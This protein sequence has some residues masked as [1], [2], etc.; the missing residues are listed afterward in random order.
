[1]PYPPLKTENYQ[2]I[3]GIN[4]KASPYMTGTNETLDLLNLDFTTPGAYTTRPGTTGWISGLTGPVLS[5]TQFSRLNGASYLIFTNNGNLYSY[6]GGSLHVQASGSTATLLSFAPFVDRLFL[7]DGVGFL[8]DTGTSV[9]AFSLPPP[10]GANMFNSEAVSNATTTGFTG[11]FVYGFAWV[12]D[13]GYIGPVAANNYNDI[14]SGIPIYDFPGIQFSIAGGSYIIFTLN[15]LANVPAGYGISYLAIFRAGPIAGNGIPFA[16]PVAAV[17]YIPAWYQLTNL[18]LSQVTFIDQAA[19]YGPA[20][21]TGPTLGSQALWFTLAPR[22]L[23]VYNNALF[24]AGFSSLPSTV[25]FSA[26]GEPELIGVTQ[27][28]QVR[29]NDSDVLTGMCNYISQQM[30]FKNRSFFS[31]NGTDSTNYTLNQISDEYGCISNRAAVVFND[32]L[33]FL[34]QK[35]LCQYNGSQVE[36]ISNRLESVFKRMN[37]VAAQDHAAMLHVKLRNEVWALFPIDGATFNNHLVVYDYVANAFSEWSGP[38]MASMALMF[39]PNNQFTPTFG[40]YTSS[41]NYFNATLF[42]DNGR[43]FTCS[44]TPRYFGGQGQEL[45]YSVEKVFR[46]LYFDITDSSNTGQTTIFDIKLLADFTGM[47]LAGRQTFAMAAGHTQIR[48]DFGVPGKAMTYQMAYLPQT[49]AL[50][51]NGFT[52][53]YRFQRN[54]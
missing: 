45:G 19:T 34:D 43:A 52:I 20:N 46:R 42:T 21:P 50:N 24:M 27:S 35:G 10:P 53:E 12:N 29:T 54:T 32:I 26:V 17:S 9:S 38:Q 39:D 31:L 7:A 8:K 4:K 1:M 48:L 23:N 25:Y 16:G 33:W 37:L 15:A 51:F 5:L 40:D 14:F 13:R 44:V 22:F 11:I 2:N 36:I 30:I 28:F 41:I 6:Y 18:P 3:G 47:T 49:P